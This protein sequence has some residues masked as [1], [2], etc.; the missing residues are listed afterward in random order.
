MWP[1][2]K[3]RNDYRA[4]VVEP[5]APRAVSQGRW[6][7]ENVTTQV[8][9][10]DVVMTDEVASEERKTN[11]S[12]AA[13]M[14]KM[15][16]EMR[17]E[18]KRHEEELA[19]WR[20][21]MRRSEERYE[22]DRRADKAERAQQHRELLM[23]LAQSREREVCPSDADQTDSGLVGESEVESEDSSFVSESEARTA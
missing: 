14:A 17:E 1:A 7:S 18:A 12:H 3:R 22:R 16:Q 15:R 10:R 8:K 19:E 9:C 4:S 5:D 21:E 13:I 23:A 2:L 20:R 11:Q 6:P